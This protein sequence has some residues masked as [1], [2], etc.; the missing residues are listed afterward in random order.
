[1]DKV[2]HVL[3]APVGG[4]FRHVRD[5]VARQA[6]TGLEVGVVCDSRASDR[7]T[8]ERLAQLQPDLKLGLHTTAMSRD[9][10]LK[11]ASA[12]AAVRDLARGAG[13]T[14]L[15]GHGAKG[16]AYARLAAAGLRRGGYPIASFYTPH[17]GSL[18]Y[19]PSSLKG[20]IFMT[21]E[22]KLAD[23]TS[24][25]IFESAYSQR[26]YEAH[27]GAPS[28]AVRVIPNG[29]LPDEFGFHAPAPDAADVLF[30]GEL[31]RLKGV[32]VLIEALGRINKVR[33]VSGCIVGDGPDAAEFRTQAAGLGLGSVVAFPGAM[34]AREAFPMGRVL[35]MPSRAESFPYIVLEAAAARIPLIATEVGGIPE[36]VS[37]TDTRLIQPDDPGALVAALLD[38]LDGPAAAQARAVRLA[39]AVAQRFTV[40]RMARDI[41]EFYQKVRLR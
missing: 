17:G 4:L 22:R 1:M 18:H 11:D 12:Y 37:G 36:I 41:G 15:H 20:R 16:G 6:A 26:V 13:A 32:D 27:V 3:R 7:L 39:D 8:K 24:G 10:S 19:H 28:C 34:P 23:M 5:L 30:I 40:E 33:E 31:R 2:I 35:A 21:L 38:A 29:V 9:I 25:I 14:I